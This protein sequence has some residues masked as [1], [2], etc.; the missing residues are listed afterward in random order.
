[1]NSIFC[2]GGGGAMTVE[3]ECGLRGCDVM[4]TVRHNLLPPSPS[5]KGYNSDRRQRCKDN[6]KIV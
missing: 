2:P 1:M 5:A 4:P 3:R 6:I